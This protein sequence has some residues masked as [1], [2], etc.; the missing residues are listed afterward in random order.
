MHAFHHSSFSI[1]KSIAFPKHLSNQNS[2]TNHENTNES[3][4]M[5]FHIWKMYSELMI[6]N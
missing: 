6:R 2:K 4:M 5:Q 3:D 1:Y